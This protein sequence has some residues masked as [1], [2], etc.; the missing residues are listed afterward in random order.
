MDQVRLKPGIVN[1]KYYRYLMSTGLY[2]DSLSALMN[3]TYF[4]LLSR[5]HTL[6][7]ALLW[8]V[9]MALASPKSLGLQHNLG[10]TFTALHSVLSWPLCKESAA[11]NLGSA[12]LNLGKDST[13][14]LL[15]YAHYSKDG[16]GW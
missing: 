2:D 5:F 15:L 8:K 10:F 16:N 1:F 6:H 14:P 4:C 3:T 12:N 7:S 9:L 11:T 13:N